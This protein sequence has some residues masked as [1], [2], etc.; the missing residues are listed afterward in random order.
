MLSAKAYFT[1]RL[2][3]S[4][5]KDVKSDWDSV[6]LEQSRAETVE[7]RRHIYLENA[8]VDSARASHG[9]LIALHCT[10]KEAACRQQAILRN[11]NVESLRLEIDPAYEAVLDLTNTKITDHIVVNLTRYFE[12]EVRKE[13]SIISWLFGWRTSP[14][15]STYMIDA[16]PPSFSLL[17]KGTV[18]LPP[19][20]FFNVKGYDFAFQE[21]ERG[22]ICKA[23]RNY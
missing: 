20:L 8:D 19:N 12:F 3:N 1:V 9:G 6:T 22:I 10:L 5:A 4:T 17:I 2:T 11:S 7:A 18:G 15:I 21:T 13:S 16:R 23:T 14:K